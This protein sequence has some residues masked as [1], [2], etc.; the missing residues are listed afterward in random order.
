M[1]PD[2]F[3]SPEELMYEYEHYEPGFDDYDY[4]DG[5]S[6]LTP[7][8]FNQ[9]LEHCI[10]PTVKDGLKHVGK[11]IIWCVLFRLTTQSGSG[12]GPISWT[13][14]LFSVTTGIIVLAHFFYLNTLY[15]LAL[16]A[17]SYLALR[18]VNYFVGKGRGVAMAVV[19]ITFNLICELYVA[20]PHDWH[21]IRGAQMILVMKAVS[22]G[23]DMDEAVAE[24]V[25]KDQDP[26]TSSQEEETSSRKQNLRNRR[27][28]FNHSDSSSSLT[29]KPSHDLTVVPTIFEYF[30]YTLC[31]GNCI[32]GPW[33]KYSDYLDIFIQ[34]RWVSRTSSNI[35]LRFHIII[36]FFS[37]PERDMVR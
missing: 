8:T 18:S 22:L 27:N 24:K 35:V 7:F 17:L 29:S 11:A 26:P 2:D 37:N 23:F 3:A 1:D 30:G 16:S 28:K 10:E 13:A 19:C 31:P 15:L 20:L 6:G 4:D 5:K 33:V 25:V 21:Q 9:I 36:N 12:N 14:H 34:P 32:F